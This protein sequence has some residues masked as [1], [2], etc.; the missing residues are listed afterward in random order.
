MNKYTHTAYTVRQQHRNCQKEIL[1]VDSTIYLLTT[2]R[3]CIHDDDESQVFE[4][5]NALKRKKKVFLTRNGMS[6]REVEHN[7]YSHES[8]NNKRI[9]LF[10]FLSFI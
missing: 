10:H 1:F 4:C 8:S 3:V 5:M 2:I 9:Q 6:S 7:E